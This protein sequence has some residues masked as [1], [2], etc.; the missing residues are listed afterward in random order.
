[1]TMMPI[2]DIDLA[3]NQTMEMKPIN[4]NEWEIGELSRVPNKIGCVSCNCL[5]P[6]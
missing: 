6:Y 4:E 2:L 1:M 5:I 3:K